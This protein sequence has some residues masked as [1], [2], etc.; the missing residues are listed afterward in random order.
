M[1]TI[2][3]TVIGHKYMKLQAASTN[4]AT[5]SATMKNIISVSRWSN[6]VTIAK[7]EKPISNETAFRNKLLNTGTVHNT[8]DGL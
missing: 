8:P 4:A 7:Y 6:A 3:A 2:S 5:T 1:D